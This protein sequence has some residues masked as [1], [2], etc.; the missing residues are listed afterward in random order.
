MRFP[1]R[2]LEFYGFAIESKSVGEW[3]T[4][5]QEEKCPF[6]GKKCVKQ[7]KSEP[8]QTIGAC[9]LGYRGKPL[10]VCPHRF[11]DRGTIFADVLH[12]LEAHESSHQ[13]CVVPEVSMPGG[14][15]DY[16]VVSMKGNQIID[17]LGLETQGLD[18]T[19]SGGIWKARQDLL[20]G[21][22]Q[23][24][25]PYGINWKMSAKTVLVQMHHKAGSFDSIRKKLIL[26]TQEDFFNYVSREFQTNHLA[27]ART[28]DIMHFHVY[29]LTLED[30]EFKLVLADRKSTG[31]S[32]VE[33]M[34]QLAKGR[35]ISEAE[36]INRIRA[37]LEDAIP[38]QL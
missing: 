15:I 19:G 31:L 8:W 17:Y 37:K 16:F 26:V 34:L 5:L 38:L 35:R 30:A 1:K 12:L 9:T 18:T 10:I 28:E 20:A 25:Y 6:L 36:V 29:R 27:T 21:R 2:P 14:S 3:H 24:T 4:I 7:R 33:Q 23:D 11:L 22:L 13:V 32:G